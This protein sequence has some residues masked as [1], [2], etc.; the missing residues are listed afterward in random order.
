M[1]F[2]G[3]ADFICGSLHQLRDR[4]G[5]LKQPLVGLSQRAAVAEKAQILLNLTARAAQFKLLASQIAQ[6][7]KG[8]SPIITAFTIRSACRNMPHAER[9]CGS[10]PTL[11]A[12]WR[13]DAA[14]AAGIDSP[15]FLACC[16]R[17]GMTAEAG[18]STAAAGGR[19]RNGSSHHSWGYGACSAGGG[20]LLGQ[21]RVEGYRKN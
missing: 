12:G 1:Q 16:G 20:V 15:E 17:G 11:L 18:G 13:A 19:R 5:P 10:S 3:G 4:A 7:T 8:T 2:D 9:S 14:L 21:R 6:V